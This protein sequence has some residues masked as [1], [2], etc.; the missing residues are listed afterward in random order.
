MDQTKSTRLKV[1]G[2]R[3]YHGKEGK[4]RFKSLALGDLVTFFSTYKDGDSYK[5]FTVK[6]S[7]GQLSH[8]EISDLKQLPKGEGSQ[9]FRVLIQNVNDVN[10]EQGLNLKNRREIEEKFA[11]FWINYQ[12][13][14]IFFNGTELNFYS[15]IKNT[16]EDILKYEINNLTYS[17]VIKII[18]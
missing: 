14:K 18:E 7:N 15:L 4:G 16:Y 8:S 10:T 5:A 1:L 3:S 11:S 6:I 13:F 17:F 9:G 2:G 12:N